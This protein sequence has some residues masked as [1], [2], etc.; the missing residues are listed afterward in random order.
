MRDAEVSEKLLEWYDRS[1]RVMP[2]RIG[3]AERKAGQ[4]P[5]PYR[6]WLSEVMLQQTTVAAVTAYFTRF[7]ALV[8]Y[9]GNDYVENGE[10]AHH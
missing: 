4:R 3:P 10:R 6:I 2:W 7:V 9:H 5:D 8:F 1:A